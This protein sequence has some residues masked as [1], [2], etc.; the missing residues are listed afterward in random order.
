M[1][2]LSEEHKEKFQ[3][4]VNKISSN[5]ES[6]VK[7]NIINEIKILE[8]KV[9]KKPSKKIQ[10]L[11]DNSK[12][13]F[14]ILNAEDFPITDSSKKWIIFGLGYLV[15]DVDLIPDAIPLIGYND[16]AMIVSWVLSLVEDDIERYSFYKKAKKI[17]ETGTALKQ[18]VQGHG[19][20]HF[21]LVNGFTE[22]TTKEKDEINWAK[23]IRNLKLS[24]DSPGISILD[25]DIS[26]LK[27]FS[28]TIPMIDHKLSLKPIYDSEVFGIEWKQLK[29]D[30]KNLGNAIYRE[31]NDIAQG[32]PDREVIIICTDAGSISII[33]AFENAKGKL[34]D[35]LI[36]LG[37]TSTNDD[38]YNSVA[39]KV[40]E[41]YNLF[42][43]NDHLIE[44]IYNNY[45][46]CRTPIGLG[47]IHS[48]QS[49]NFI[50]K[51]VSTIINRHHD[52]KYK[53]AEVI[54][55]VTK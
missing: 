15:S 55:T 18:L 30:M 19:D 45:E 36:I 44:F 28:K 8:E 52:Y 6:K 26:Y 29:L 46:E 50:N 23:A 11:I 5:D 2:T 37:G 54:N 33:S 31:L 7:K 3:N 16:D 43:E 41:S 53:M 35:K 13:L 22:I 38:L 9:A 12:L 40:L 51:D 14:E 27:E 21:I 32:S 49:I 20:Q 10:T 34:A 4:Q 42:S 47:G 17:S 39:N 1:F 48:E 25:W 24:T